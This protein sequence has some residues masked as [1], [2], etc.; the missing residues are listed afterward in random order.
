MRTRI[1][2]AWNAIPIFLCTVFGRYCVLPCKRWDGYLTF[3]IHQLIVN[4]ILRCAASRMPVLGI[5]LFFQRLFPFFPSSQ[6]KRLTLIV[7]VGWLVGR[8][9][10]SF[11]F[12]QQRLMWILMKWL[13][14]WSM[15][16]LSEYVGKNFERKCNFNEMLRNA[17]NATGYNKELSKEKYNVI[18]FYIL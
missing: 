16:I 3:I 7:V 6:T 9:L 1:A 14:T 5:A 15:I 17:K 8:S 10:S 12:L 13:F 18:K 11:F 2:G 4:T